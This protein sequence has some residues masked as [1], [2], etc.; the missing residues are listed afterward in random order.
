MI[1]Q[2][3]LP[4]FS[5]VAHTGH[6]KSTLAAPFISDAKRGGIGIRTDIMTC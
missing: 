6:G 1:S 4:N 2:T 3:D 5:I